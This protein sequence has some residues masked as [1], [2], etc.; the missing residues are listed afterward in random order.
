M[1]N[2]AEAAYY[3]EEED[4][5]IAIIEERIELASIMGNS[6]TTSI[7]QRE[8][9]SKQPVSIITNQSINNR[10]ATSSVTWE[11]MLSK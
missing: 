9:K 8:S 2:K 1:K 10:L 4:D 5:S 11:T 3:R 7:S 6:T